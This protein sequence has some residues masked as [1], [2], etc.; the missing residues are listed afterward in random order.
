MSFSLLALPT[1]QEQVIAEWI[2]LQFSQNH[3]KLSIKNFKK[4]Y[5]INFV[6]SLAYGRCVDLQTIGN[7]F[8]INIMRD[9]LTENDFHHALFS[10]I[11][12]IN[13]KF[14]KELYTLLFNIKYKKDPLLTHPELVVLLDNLKLVEY[15]LKN[16]ELLIEP[17][18]LDLGQK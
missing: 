17:T 2:E 14:Q 3:S 5:S 7:K 12:F 13:N 1:E 11:T 16:W 6:T 10:K 18:P 15:F 8:Q 9:C 4:K